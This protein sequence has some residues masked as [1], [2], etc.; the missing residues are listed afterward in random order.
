[1]RGAG[2]RELWSDLSPDFFCYALGVGRADLS[3][4][5]FASQHSRLGRYRRRLERQEVQLRHYNGLASNLVA[6]IYGQK[7]EQF[8]A[9]ENNIFGDVS[10]IDFMMRAAAMQPDHCD[11]FTFESLGTII[12]GL[13]TFRD[14]SVRRFYTVYFNPAFAASSPGTV[15]LYEVTRQ[16]LAAGLDCDYMTGEQPHKKRFA[17][18]RV[19]LFRVEASAD[20]VAR[21][22]RRVELISG[23]AA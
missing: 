22:A 5:Q 3:A 9:D 6:S 1:L 16:T 10:R 13:I 15:L 12:A 7:A 17:T 2:A 18:S 21:A 20:V 19:P 23:P 8:A 4:E 14:R 11:V